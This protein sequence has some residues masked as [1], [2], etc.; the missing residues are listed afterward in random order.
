MKYTSTRNKK[1]SISGTKAIIQGI[2]TDGGLFVP[3]VFHIL[4]KSDFEKFCS[5][6]YSERASFILE[7]FLPEFKETLSSSTQNAYSKFED[8][9]GAP[10]IKVD[11]N[12][13]FLELWH[14]PTY[15]FKDIALTLLP[16]LLVHSKTLEG[17]K[18]KTLILVATSGD[19][20]KA[21][22]EGF[23]DIENTAIACLYPEDGVSN[24]QKLQ[25][26]TTKGSNVFVASVKGNFD[27]CQN[28]VKDIFANNELAGEFTKNGI[29]LSSA[30]SINIGRLLPQVVYY[31][32]A[33]ADMVNAEQI[34][35]GD[36]IKFCVPTG[37]FGN[38]L[39]GY[40]AYKMG[41]PVNKFICASNQNKVLADFFETGIYDLRNREFYKSTSPSMD[42]LISSNLERL[43]FEFSNRND[44]LTQNRMND[45]K[46]KGFYSI[47]DNELKEIQ[48]LFIGDFASE[49][50]VLETIEEI[51]D[52]YGY[53]LDPHTAVA[54]SVNNKYND[55][56]DNKNKMPT[57][58][59]ST[60]SPYKFVDT[61]LEAIGETVP[62]S[63]K[64]AVEK[65]EYIT[66]IEMP[67]SLTELFSMPVL[68]NNTLEKNEIKK[69]LCK[70]IIM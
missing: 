57:V 66:A 33:Y 53:V 27:D 39:A 70:K 68:H 34:K 6:E 28:A 54:V 23:S 50:D 5:M 20:G 49:D 4:K 32:S 42:I 47:S 17:D 8:E 22:L 10:L 1:V 65:L 18:T 31:F 55:G 51:Y 67:N 30:N 38:I 64:K 26:Q 21:A 52:E 40:Y 13:Y 37:N 16:H 46:Q 43:I 29:T 3:E 62:K 48:K 45:L 36:K 44:V 59:V 11:E 19:T 2:S 7:M 15:A 69:W 63:D 60:A 56:V 58:I 24:L 14:G 41:L 35:Y 12:L 9:D 61:V 25:M